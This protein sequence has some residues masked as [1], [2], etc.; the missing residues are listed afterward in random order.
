MLCKYYVMDFLWKLT[1]DHQSL[2]VIS[3]IITYRHIA[4]LSVQCVKSLSYKIYNELDDL[5]S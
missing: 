1:I 2:I 4:E 5:K 3:S